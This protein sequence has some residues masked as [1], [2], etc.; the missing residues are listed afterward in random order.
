MLRFV[1]AANGAAKIGNT[2]LAQLICDHL[3]G[4]APHM[5]CD[6]HTREYVQEQM[7]KRFSTTESWRTAFALIADNSEMTVTD[8]LDCAA[9]IG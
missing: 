3:R 8:I 9:L 6:N 5:M 2:V 1:A 4:A 7:V